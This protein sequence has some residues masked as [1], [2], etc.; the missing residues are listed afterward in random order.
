MNLDPPCI[1][2]CIYTCIVMIGF[3]NSTFTFL[4]GLHLFLFRLRMILYI[5]TNRTTQALSIE[6]LG[7][8]SRWP[9]ISCCHVSRI[10]W[11]WYDLFFTFSLFCL[12]YPCLNVSFILRVHDMYSINC[13]ISNFVFLLFFIGCIGIVD[14][15]TVELN[16]LHRQVAFSNLMLIIFLSRILSLQCYIWLLPVFCCSGTLQR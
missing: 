14:G 8:W 13:N 11:G 5:S 12:Y 10:M 6:G 9:W 1:K 16:N 4:R 2:V 3:T 7:N 15:D